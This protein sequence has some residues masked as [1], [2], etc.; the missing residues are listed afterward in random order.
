MPEQEQPGLE[1]DQEVSVDALSDEDL[2]EA[3]FGESESTDDEPTGGDDQIEESEDE[4]SGEVEPDAAEKAD[5]PDEAEPPT[6]IE[7]LRAKLEAAEEQAKHFERVAGGHAG[8]I[9]YLEKRLRE[10]EEAGSRSRPTDEFGDDV[11]QVPERQVTQSQN[12][13]R[14]ESAV[15]IKLAMEQAAREVYAA[16]PDLIIAGENGEQ[17]IDPKFTESLGELRANAEQILSA[18]TA[19]EAYNRTA[20]LLGDAAS[21]Y[22]AVRKQV[23]AQELERRRA[24]SAAKLKQEKRAASVSTSTTVDRQPPTRRATSPQQMTDKELEQAVAEM[25]AD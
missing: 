14:Q 13:G 11:E 16:N 4:P 21:K 22:K 25:S 18:S 8:K 23:L 10:L 1:Q 7:V 17:T 24:D 19:D 3:L 9:G 12:G 15:S 20:A 6:E 5:A 2:E